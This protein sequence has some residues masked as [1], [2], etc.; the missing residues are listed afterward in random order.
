[1]ILHQI[2]FCINTAFA[3]S[4]DV[5]NCYNT[6]EFGDLGNSISCSNHE[7]ISDVA[8]YFNE[9]DSYTVYKNSVSANC[10]FHYEAYAAAHSFLLSLQNPFSFLDL[11]CGDAVKST[12]ILSNLSVNY[13]HGVDISSF[14]LKKAES[15]YVQQNISAPAKFTIADFLD[16]IQSNSNQYDN[17]TTIINENERLMNDLNYDIIFIGLSLHHL[18][19]HDKIKFLSATIQRLSPGGSL[20]I[21]E[22]TLSPGISL[23]IYNDMIEEHFRQNCTILTSAQIITTMTHIR[24]S[25]YPELISTYQTI[26]I[27]AQ[28]KDVKV[29]YSSPGSY[30]SLIAFMT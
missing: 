20:L 19:I 28:F 9:S 30:Y 21:Y 27:S 12:S 7:D 15:N 5:Q 10:L 24:T 2:I 3:F 18:P 17:V 23:S 22:P 4:F 29:L 13:Y 1:M 25:D 11:G 8:K 26:G 14:S 16:F 6:N